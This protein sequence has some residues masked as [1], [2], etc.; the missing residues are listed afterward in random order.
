MTSD[1]HK[2]WFSADSEASSKSE[3]RLGRFA[4]AKSL[5]RAVAHWTSDHSLTVA[6]Y[7][8]Y[9]SG[10]S[11][12]KRMAVEA[13]AD[14]WDLSRE[15]TLANTLDIA[16]WSWVNPGDWITAFFRELGLTVGAQISDPA[17]KK[18]AVT[19]FSGL[20]AQVSGASAV[21]ET[22]AG[23]AL[24]VGAEAAGL[25][26]AARVFKGVTDLFKTKSDAS[27]AEAGSAETRTLEDI[28]REIAEI[29]AQRKRPL[30]VFVD[31]IDRLTAD[32]I[33]TL[34][35]VVRA[36][37]DFPNL[38]FVLLFHRSVVEDALKSEGASGRDYLEKIVQV[39][40]DLPEPPRDHFPALFADDLADAAANVAHL[41]AADRGAL[42]NELG[43]WF[44]S[45][46]HVYVRTPR[47][48]VR[49]ANTYRFYL[50]GFADDALETSRD[51]AIHADSTG[52]RLGV[53]PLDLLLL[54]VL[55]THESEVYHRI[56]RIKEDL[57]GE[58]P[59]EIMGTVEERRKQALANLVA[60]ADDRMAVHSILVSLFPITGAVLND[61]KMALAALRQFGA[62]W[63][64]DR[65][66]AHP[67]VFDRYFAFT[68]GETHS[69]QDRIE[70]LVDEH[71]DQ[72]LVASRLMDFAR[73]GE[74]EA[75]LDRVAAF[76][77][78]IATGDPASFLAGY[79]EVGDRLVADLP[80]GLGPG[81]D[82]YS[83]INVTK[84]VLAA[85]KAHG[86]SPET[87]LVQALGRTG[88][89]VYPVGVAEDAATEPERYGLSPSIAPRLDRD[90]LGTIR[91]ASKTGALINSPRLAYLLKRWDVLERQLVHE[92]G[93]PPE[94]TTQQ[95]TWVQK[96]TDE[97]YGIVRILR[98]Y[99]GL[100]PTEDPPARR[101][102]WDT[103]DTLLNVPALVQTLSANLYEVDSADR[104][105]VNA[106][107][108]A[109]EARRVTA[110]STSEPEP[111]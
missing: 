52:R 83:A 18:R 75:A 78:Q 62:E 72:S 110:K 41:I 45:T 86:G 16:P 102:N 80:G 99:S 63:A 53:D 70:V 93:D 26:P 3:D 100:D 71:D 43:E 48:V 20:A 12:A 7:G 81:L 111:D 47:E 54:E 14:I 34:F 60:L 95:E 49:L 87:I 4:F 33:R 109:A 88:G 94:G 17:Q 22:L 96:F 89:L 10:K 46:L 104:P 28:K 77:D 64:R 38:V 31:E 25:G 73:R 42:R 69:F 27:Q 40:L 68:A 32:E 79:F 29:L 76:T 15:E 108:E 36:N 44:R 2:I 56:P 57:V 91:A 107:L 24:L 74:L 67:D 92:D 11:S 23:L 98:A 105:L 37:T 39:G 30:I 6:L 84:T 13:L 101:F 21:V 8:E 35:R 58:Y 90:V 51:E 85:I 103:L 1:T 65:R 50:G 97:P 9:G 19:L 59:M 106:F 66:A 61:D 55:R 82:G 5:A